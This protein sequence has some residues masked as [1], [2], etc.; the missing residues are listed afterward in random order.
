MLC[1]IAFVYFCVPECK[2]KTLE[3]IDRLFLDGVP[4]RKFE[5]TQI[6]VEHVD[7]ND[8]EGK[9]GAAAKIEI[10]ES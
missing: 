3:E 9:E 8:T 7:A 1:S 5:K 2:G 6:S 10:V 4:L